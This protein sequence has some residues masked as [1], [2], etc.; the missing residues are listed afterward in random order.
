MGEHVT[1]TSINRIRLQEENKRTETGR[2]GCRRSVVA[3]LIVVSAALAMAPVWVIQFFAGVSHAQESLPVAETS[4]Q[5]LRVRG[6]DIGGQWYPLG[7]S[8][9][10]RGVAIV[11]LATQCPISNGY[12]PQ[13]N[14]L[15][16]SYAKKG[17]EFYGVISDRAVTRAEAAKHR[18]EY[19][20][21]FPVLFDASGELRAWLGPTHTPQAFVLDAGLQIIYSGQVDDRYAALGR[22][23]GS[24]QR[25]YLAN[26]LQALV[27]GRPIAVSRTEPIGC[28]MEDPVDEFADS[29][30]TYTRDIAPVIAAN[31][32]SC[33]R[34][35]GGGPFS[36]VTYEEV[37]R[38]AG[39]LSVVV[40]SRLMPPWKPVPGIR[41]FVGERWLSP[42]EIELFQQWANAGAPRGDPADLPPVP[43]FPVGWQLGTP[44]LI[45]E[46]P[47]E[48]ELHADG[49]D[50]YQHFVLPSGLLEDRLVSAIEFRPGNPAICHHVNVYLDSSGKA[51]QL[52]AAWPGPG[53]HR[54]GSHGFVASGYLG[55]WTPGQTPRRLPEGTGALMPR[56][57]DV[58]LQIH[59]HPTGKV[60]RD[61]SSVGIYFAPRSARQ[62]VGQLFVG[63]VELEIPAGEANYRHHCSYTLPAGVTLLSVKPHMH[64]LGREARVTAI[65][66]NGRTEPLV[67]ID[68]WDFNWQDHYYFVKPVRLPAGTTLH[69]E[70]RYD[71]SAG[72]PQNPHSPPR[73]VSFGEGSTDEMASCF[74]RMTADRLED[75]V[76]VRRDNERYFD[77]KLR[78][79]LERQQTERS[80]P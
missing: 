52:D 51:R 14:T 67:Q 80:P 78:R 57:C 28:L 74:F 1:R 79:Y 60:E 31:C 12:L 24:A 30:V 27:T 48:F 54:F 64:L 77:E 15:A 72:N 66:P 20:I 11:F 26:A 45:L 19:R 62:L 61:R 23:R 29:P 76:R 18:E 70:V 33:H 17:I 2:C 71:N 75:Y 5:R 35:G 42:R 32:L 10:C 37:S 53:Y 47:E 58:V 65:L 50:R 4:T 8:P 39:Q 59:Y 21:R 9:G 3:A 49:P 68:D 22:R 6:A 69:F 25:R 13:L 34:A 38:R 46:M 56:G 43:E 73:D 40:E 7:E 16:A 41:H 44:D 36:L 63:S 55:G